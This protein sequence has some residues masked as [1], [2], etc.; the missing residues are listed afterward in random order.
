MSLKASD[1]LARGMFD[2]FQARI[3]R[4]GVLKGAG[5]TGLG[6]LAGSTGYL[7]TRAQESPE[8][9]DSVNVLITLES[10]AVTMLGVARERGK[11]MKLTDDDVRIIRAA[12]C[13]EDAHYHFLE[14]S[15]GAPSTSTASLANVVFK[16]RATFLRNWRDFEEISVAA[17]MAAVTQFAQLGDVLECRRSRRRVGQP[18]VYRRIGQEIRLSGPGRHLLPRCL[19][20]RPRNNRTRFAFTG[21]VARGITCGLPGGDSGI[22]GEII[23]VC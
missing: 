17:Y 9:Q 20:S 19:R 14:A 5:L 10:V 12:Q 18:G 6:A 21:S 2:K 22:L 23:W 11:R 3:T 4:R 15:G 13:E 1:L 8:V 7:R 16:N